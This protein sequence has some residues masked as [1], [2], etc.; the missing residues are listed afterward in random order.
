[1]DA[2]DGSQVW[3]F[4]LQAPDVYLL[5]RESPA[6][7]RF[8]GLP[9]TI[10]ETLCTIC[11][12]RIHVCVCSALQCSLSGGRFSLRGGKQSLFLITS[13]H[14]LQEQSPA[15]LA[16]GVRQELHLSVSKPDQCTDMIIRYTAKVHQHQEAKTCSSAGTCRSCWRAQENTLCL[17]S[18][19]SGCSRCG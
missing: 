16:D 18:M 12:K 6:Q 9:M 2:A 13:I 19:S 11:K 15:E 3:A 7:S 14:Q 4:A 5:G 1:M 10:L 8:G 17:W